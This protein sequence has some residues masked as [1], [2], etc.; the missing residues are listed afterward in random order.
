V[1]GD[2]GAVKFE[3]GVRWE[4]TDVHINDATVVPAPADTRYD[5]D[6]LLPSASVK[7]DTGSGRITASVARTLRRPQFDFLTPVTLEEELGDNDF[8][9]NPLLLPEKAWGG[10]LGYEHR[11][12]RNGVVG[13]NV[14][15]RK[16]D[17]LIELATVLDAAGDPLPGSANEDDDDVVA[18]VLQPVNAGDGE[19]YGVEFDLSTDLGFLG[20]PDTGVFGNVSWLDSDIDDVFGA[21]RFNSQSEFVY[22]FGVIHNLRAFGA[23]FGA[24]YRKQGSAFGRL[25]SEEVTTSYGADLEIFVEKRFG[26]SFTIR[27]V[28]SNLLDGKKREVFNKFSTIEDQVDRDFD[29]YE[30]ESERAGPVFQLVGRFAF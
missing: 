25:I 5:Y 20:L 19:V 3:A 29:E 22:N 15:Y 13:V 9:G 17:D 27:A 30:L 4:T 24:T 1:E 21:R 23:A 18:F 7:F 16:V 11:L 6:V 28:G 10:D 8:L 12:G 14:F 26:D 2:L